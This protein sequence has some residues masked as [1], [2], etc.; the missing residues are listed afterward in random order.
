MQVAWPSVSSI[1]GL[2]DHQAEGLAPI[3]TG[4]RLGVLEG[5]PGTGKTY[6]AAALIRAWIAQNGPASIAIAAP[7]GK[8]AV[9]I[10]EAMINNGLSG[11]QAKTIHSLLKVAEADGGDGWKFEF[12]ASN[13]LPQRLIVCDE[14]SMLDT[15]LTYSLFSA[16]ED[17]AHVLL[18]GD[19]NQLPPVGH[20]APLRDI[21]AAG[22]PHCRLTEIHRNAGSIVQACHAIAAGKMFEWD[23]TLDWQG[24]PP[25]NLKL[26]QA[27]TPQQQID[28]MLSALKLVE[29]EELDPIADIQILAAVIA[30]SLLAGK[31]LEQVF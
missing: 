1:H 24:T 27:G 30:T 12:N 9:R 4:G 2:S 20:G 23:E 16:L 17:N 14:S 31:A 21:I 22:A 7:T 8:A 26:V 11:L 13:P 29:R 28:K 6:T 18:V 25:R 10:T 19:I 5:G 3:L 15:S